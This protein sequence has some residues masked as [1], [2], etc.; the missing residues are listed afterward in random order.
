MAGG[1]L[2]TGATEG[3]TSIVRVQALVR[4][5]LAQRV[6]QW[7]RCKPQAFKHFFL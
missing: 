1:S 7:E 3:Q 2:L 5:W 6:A 4:R